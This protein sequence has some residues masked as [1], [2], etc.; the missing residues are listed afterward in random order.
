MRE[1]KWSKIIVLNVTGIFLYM[2]GIRCFATPAKIAPGGA[3]GIAI[4]VNHMTGFPIGVFC[5][6]FN[7]P[8]LAVALYKKIFSPVFAGKAAASI[9]LQIGRAH[10]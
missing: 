7:L 8:I 6:L 9:L 4:L 2:I 10:V 3:S 1:Q 5:S